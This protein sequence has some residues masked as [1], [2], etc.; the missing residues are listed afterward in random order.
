MRP[1]IRPWLLALLASLLPLSA[2]AD[3]TAYVVAWNTLYRLDLSTARATRIGNGVGFNDIEGLAFSPDGTLYGIADGTA[4][5]GSAQTD[6]L[7]RINP[8]TGAGTLVGQF[9]GLAGQG[10]NG[11]LDYG[12]A[13]TCDGRLWASSDTTG[14]FWEIDPRNAGVREVGNTGAPLSDLTARGNQLFAIGVRTGFGDP[15]QQALY[16][17]DPSTGIPTRIGSLG[18][19]DNLSSAGLDFDAQGI[20]W[21]TLDS[22]PPDFDRPSRLARIDT[23]TGKATVVGSISGIEDNLSARAMAISVPGACDGGDDEDRPNAA[24]PTLVPGPG[25]PALVL[26]G[27]LAAWSGSRRLRRA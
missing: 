19:D 6:F 7:I 3:T 16:S 2:A 11:Q 14:R 24:P 17:L 1:P 27:L 20:L 9:P 25:T 12:L 8:A 21:A 23:A 22:Q 10:P 4:G 26:L 15:Q 13:F 5:T 18:V